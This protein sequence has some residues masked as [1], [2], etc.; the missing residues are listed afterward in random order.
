MQKQKVLKKETDDVE[1]LH[2]LKWEMNEVKM[3]P[4][5]SIFIHNIKADAVAVDKTTGRRSGLVENS[6]K[7]P[8]LNPRWRVNGVW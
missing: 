1:D 6:K 4:K 7:F 8:G 3:M 5:H 2:E